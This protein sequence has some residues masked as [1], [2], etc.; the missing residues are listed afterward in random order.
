MLTGEAEADS[1]QGHDTA[2]SLAWKSYGP[3]CVSVTHGDRTCPGLSHMLSL[4]VSSFIRVTVEQLHNAIP[5][6]QFRDSHTHTLP[7]QKKIK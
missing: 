4:P 7:P 2:Q 1:C 6:L 3:E 5:F